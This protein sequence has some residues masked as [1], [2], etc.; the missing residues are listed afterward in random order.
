MSPRFACYPTLLLCTEF[1]CTLD[2]PDF[3][4]HPAPNIL[5]TPSCIWLIRSVYTTFSVRNYFR[6]L[7]K[8]NN[9][10]QLKKTF[11]P[12]PDV[13]ARG[14]TLGTVILITKNYRRLQTTTTNNYRQILFTD[15]RQKI[16][17]HTDKILTSTICQ[18]IPSWR[19]MAVISGSLL[20]ILDQ[21]SEQKDTA[22]QCLM[23]F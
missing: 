14:L 19:T 17:K 12:I 13:N 11:I 10:L 9:I 20:C 5:H 6:T 1:P 23:L 15:N 18:Q 22:Q 16:L 4:P 8:S 2:F 7:S 3:P 21:F